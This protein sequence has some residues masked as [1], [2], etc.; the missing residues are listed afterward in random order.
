MHNKIPLFQRYEG[1]CTSR[2]GLYPVPP[3]REVAMLNIPD[4]VSRL[5]NAHLS[6][7]HRQAEHLANPISVTRQSQME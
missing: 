7:S 6:R 2:R 1:M 3:P 4:I 5:G